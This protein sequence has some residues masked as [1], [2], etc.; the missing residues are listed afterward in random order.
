MDEQVF[1]QD[2]K[3]YRK[4]HL[5]QVLERDLFG[6][7]AQW[8]VKGYL[9]KYLI[10]KALNGVA[11][12]AYFKT[13]YTDSFGLDIDVHDF[14]GAPLF[15]PLLKKQI[16]EVVERIG[17]PPSI[18]V[19]SPHGIHLYYF[20][21]KKAPLLKLHREVEKILQ[22]LNVEILPTEKKALRI[23]SEYSYLDPVTLEPIDPPLDFVR[24]PATILFSKSEQ[25]PGK[26][27]HNGTW[28]RLFDISTKEA[29]LFPVVDHHTNRAV[30]ECGISY[31]LAGLPLQE[32]VDRFHGLVLRSPGYNRDLRNPKRIETRFKAIYSYRARYLPS[33]RVVQI[34]LDDAII[35]NELVDRAPFAVQRKEPLRHFFME[36]FIWAEYIEKLQKTDPAVHTY[37]CSEYTYFRKNTKSGYVP[38]PF[39]LMRRWNWNYFSIIEW[40]VNIELLKPLDT[41]TSKR[42]TYSKLLGSCKYYQVRKD[43]LF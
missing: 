35:I 28:R 14:G 16:D 11:T 31:R 3:P 27:A 7:D 33:A 34:P 40:A 18:A 42:G 24:Y 4:K 17:Y 43:K 30:V 13:T 6:N 26:D 25:I 1:I 23:P 20:F 41:K 19:E 39:T 32:A 36:L 22:G 38:L 9:T 8:I 5:K 21:Q 37:M 29:E 15:A 12:L 2:F 10:H